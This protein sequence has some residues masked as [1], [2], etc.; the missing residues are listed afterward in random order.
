MPSEIAPGELRRH[1][2]SILFG[3]AGI[4]RRLVLPWLFAFVAS[5][6]RRSADIWILLFVVPA[7]V[8]AVLDFLL[9]RYVLGPD[10]LVV[11]RGILIRRIR[12]VP[13]AR[14]QNIDLR[15]N[16]LHRWLGVAEVTIQTASGE[17][18][19]ARLRV[20]SLA[21]VETLRQRVFAER[22][23]AEEGAPGTPSSSARRILLALDPGQ[24]ALFGLLHGR[25]WVVAA[26]AAGL[27]TQWLGPEEAAFLSWKPWESLPS[28]GAGL[29]AGLVAAL[30]LVAVLVLLRVLSVGW[31]FAT[32]HGFRL[33]R[34]GEDLRAT[35][36]LLTR[37]QTTIPRHRIQVLTVE[38]G[39]LARAFGRV[40]V[41]AD[42]AGGG[43]EERQG[44][45]DAARAWIA[46]VLPR[47]ALPGLLA[48]VAPEIELEAA[49]W[50]P[51]S[52]R[53][54]WRVLRKRALVSL[55]AGGLAAAVAGPVGWLAAVVVLPLAGAAG[56]LRVRTTSWA[57]LP[58]AL[59]VR[60]GWWTRRTRVVRFAKI[61]VVQTWSTWF[62]RRARMAHVLVDTAAP[63]T[64]ALEVP[65]L[66]EADARALAA[67]LAEAAERT[68]F[69]W[70]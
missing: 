58:R 8:G 14:I 23:P 42:T 2:S 17:E 13:Y 27:A 43:G 41:Q 28:L 37:R 15:Q 11:R 64:A 9:V 31:A 39:V 18:A 20:L 47:A 6:G 1:P 26:A 5:G 61:Q 53:A 38:E 68:E 25:G 16:P 10:G 66:D 4:A 69:E 12:H 63:G 59:A 46:P 29:T 36:G 44:R 19:E 57:T 3:I 7:T 49:A 33:E 45:R 51:V 48:E 65:W 40:L 52:P 34:S 21:S 35:G 54:L 60:T 30:L 32:L 50:R 70:K 24:V 55:L 62:D 22:R 67:V 56:W